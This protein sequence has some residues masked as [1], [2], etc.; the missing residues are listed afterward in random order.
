MDAGGGFPVL[1]A[2]ADLAALPGAVVLHSRSRRPERVQALALRSAGHTRLFLANVTAEAHP[3]RLEG[4]DGRL[5][6]SPLGSAAGG[7]GAETEL[8]LAPHE[9]TRIDAPPAGV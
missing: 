7:A 3:V 6:R 5:A 2:F 9:V 8:D 1:H 4:L